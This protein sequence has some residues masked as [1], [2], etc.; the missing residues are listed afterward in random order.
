M[1]S[2]QNIFIERYLLH[3]NATRAAREAGYSEK[4]ANVIGHETLTKPYIKEIVDSRIKEIVSQTDEKKASLIQFWSDM[5][6]N[7]EASETARLRASE[8]LGKYLAMFIEKHEHNVGVKIA[9][10][11]RDDADL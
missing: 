7:K 9:Y 5:V 6:Q 10:L 4:T 8:N 2:K 1:T 3:F 11:D